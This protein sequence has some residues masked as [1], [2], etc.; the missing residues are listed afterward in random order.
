MNCLIN[1]TIDHRRKKLIYLFFIYLSINKPIPLRR[2]KKPIPLLRTIPRT[3]KDKMI[4]SIGS[5]YRLIKPNNL[6]IRI[7]ILEDINIMH[8]R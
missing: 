4:K 1:K 5:V 6:V 7:I 2:P 8:Q 3:T